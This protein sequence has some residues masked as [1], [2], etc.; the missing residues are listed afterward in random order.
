MCISAAAL[1]K[2][3][4]S[5]IANVRPRRA[6]PCACTCAS[7]PSMKIVLGPP[8]AIKRKTA[9]DPRRP[10][11]QG[12]VRPKIITCSRRAGSRTHLPKLLPN[13]N[14]SSDGR[15]WTW[16]VSPALGQSFHQGSRP[17]SNSAAPAKPVS[18]PVRLGSRWR[19]WPSPP[20]APSEP[21]GIASP[22]PGARKRLVS[23]PYCFVYK[24][25]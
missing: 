24:S 6:P 16:R 22:S 18:G 10:A 9:S 13:F 3:R 11:H 12:S 7:S 2:R 5:V 21:A 17:R 20:E 4:G 14:P 23:R 25:K 8:P 19:S 15:V 1:R